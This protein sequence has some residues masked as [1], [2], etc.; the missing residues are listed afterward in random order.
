MGEST[1]IAITIGRQIGSG[2][3]ELGKRLARRLGFVLVDRQITSEAARHLGCSEQDVELRTERVSRFWQSFMRVLAI[4]PPDS[5]YAQPRPVPEIPDRDLFELQAYVIREL[6]ADKDVIVIGHAAFYILRDHP[7]LINIYTH[8]SMEDRIDR[9]MRVSKLADAE[10]ARQVA[11]RTDRER[12]RFIREM[13]GVI[14][15]DARNYDLCID[16]SRIPMEIAEEMVAS[17][18]NVR[19]AS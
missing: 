17:L 15:T 3:L 9:I 7:G 18:V 4:G 1:P 5:I 12:E 16:T 2:G 8:A 11:E 10:Q 14:W 13:A 6:A 19:R